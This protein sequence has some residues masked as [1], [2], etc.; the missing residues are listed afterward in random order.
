MRSRSI[1]TG[2]NI[3][4]VSNIPD[5]EEGKEKELIKKIKINIIEIEINL[6]HP[7]YLMR[8]L[9]I[10]YYFLLPMNGR[11]SNILGSKF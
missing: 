1:R 5:L 2:T 6:F 11:E 9:I 3:R 4:M 8:C 7:Q 10:S